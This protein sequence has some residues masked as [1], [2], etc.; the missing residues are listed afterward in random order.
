MAQAAYMTAKCIFRK[1]N[2]LGIGGIEIEYGFLDITSPPR[3]RDTSN[4]LNQTLKE[5]VLKLILINASS[6]W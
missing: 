4:V 1:L 2:N 6:P 3:H 5:W